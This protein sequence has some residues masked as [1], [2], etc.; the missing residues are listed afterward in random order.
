ME[1]IHDQ[2]K[3]THSTCASTNVF[4]FLSH[5]SGSSCCLAQIWAVGEDGGAATRA[6]KAK[7]ERG[8]PVSE[9]GRKPTL[10]TSAYLPGESTQLCR[11][12]EKSIECFNNDMR[13]S[14]FI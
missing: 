10:S 11:K 1:Y 13:R 9:A 4:L 7:G 3:V 5:P 2:Q 12:R 14:F 8:V 6:H